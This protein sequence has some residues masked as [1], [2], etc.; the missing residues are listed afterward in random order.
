[1]SG[2][3]SPAHQVPD[4]DS[5]RLLGSLLLSPYSYLPKNFA[6]CDGR[7]LPINQNTALYALL[8]DRFGGDQNSFALPNLTG[9]TP[10]K[11]LSYLIATRGIFPARKELLERLLESTRCWVN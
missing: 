4:D 9:I 7:S 2:L 6:P 5:S 10:L 1:M 8:G 3:H 11:G